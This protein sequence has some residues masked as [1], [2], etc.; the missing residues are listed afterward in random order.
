MGAIN[1]PY[2]N[3]AYCVKSHYYSK[4]DDLVSSDTLRLS[5]KKSTKI[6]LDS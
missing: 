2:G 3:L 4:R 1:R 5:K 6:A